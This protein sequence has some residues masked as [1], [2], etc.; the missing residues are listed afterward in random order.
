HLK[1]ENLTLFGFVCLAIEACKRELPEMATYN[2]YRRPECSEQTIGECRHVVLEKFLTIKD[3]SPSNEEEDEEFDYEHGTHDPDND[4]E[5]KNMKSDW[6]KSVQLWNQPEPI[7]PKEERLQPKIIETIVEIDESIGKYPIV[8]SGEERKREAE[9]DAGRKQRRCWS[10][11]LHRRF[12]QHLGG[13][14]VATPKQIRE[15]MNIGRLTNDEVKS[16]LQILLN[17]C[18]YFSSLQAAGNFTKCRSATYAMLQEGNKKCPYKHC[19]IGSTF[20]P[21]L[22]GH[23]LATSNFYYTSMF[24]ELDEKDWLAEM[25]P[26]G[27]RYCKE[28]WSELKKSIDMLFTKKKKSICLGTASHQHI[29][30]QCFTIVLVLLLMMEGKYVI[31]QIQERIEFASK[32][33]EKDIPLE[34][35]LGAFILKT[36]SATFDYADLS[37]KMLG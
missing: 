8:N 30:S 7:L 36:S 33:G 24:F 14:H 35:A 28:K 29:L 1:K 27:K 21:D 2:L 34:W 4:S 13:A 3:S 23:F 9:K 10:S 32:A 37:R 20:T 22:Q 15:L 17:T 26:A 25:I 5:D 31:T 16:H 12:F 6:L 11:Q 18:N 19:S